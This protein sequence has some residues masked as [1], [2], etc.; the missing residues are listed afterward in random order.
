MVGQ[1]V[2]GGRVQ[3]S[4]DQLVILSLLNE[5]MT[6]AKFPPQDQT[7]SRNDLEVMGKSFDEDTEIISGNIGLMKLFPEY[8]G[9]LDDLIEFT[10]VIMSYNL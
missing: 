2:Y 8:I 4:E 6:L 7:D 1:V 5:I 3:S 10:K 9:E